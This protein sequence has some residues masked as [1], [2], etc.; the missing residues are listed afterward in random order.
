M[1]RVL[2][3][4]IILVARLSMENEV[5]LTTV[6]KAIPFLWFIADT[7][8]SAN[9]TTSA[10]ASSVYLYPPSTSDGWPNTRRETMKSVL[11]LRAVAMV[12][13]IGI[14]SAYAG[15][16][17]GPSALPPSTSAQDQPHSVSSGARERPPLFT[18]GRVEV[19]VCAPVPPPYNAE[20]NGDLAARYLWGTG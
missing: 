3:A 18:I 19:R 14:G 6:G 4:F 8:I 7:S 13:S 1:A 12:F 15:G 16:N 17:D 11:V 9:L 2:A 5:M 20:A 10:N